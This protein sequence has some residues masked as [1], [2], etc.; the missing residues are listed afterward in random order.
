[1][2]RITLLEWQ[3]IEAGSFQQNIPFKKTSNQ[4]VC[5]HLANT[6][7]DRVKDGLGTAK[8]FP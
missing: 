8:C 2:R 1:L 5:R 4:S 7:L 3:Y 6:C